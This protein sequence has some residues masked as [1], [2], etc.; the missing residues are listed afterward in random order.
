NHRQVS[1]ASAC[2]TAASSTGCSVPATV[3]AE[4]RNAKR[5]NNQHPVLGSAGNHVLSTA[6]SASSPGDVVVHT[7]TTATGAYGK[8]MNND[9]GPHDFRDVSAGGIIG[10]CGSTSA[11]GGGGSTSSSA[12]TPSTTDQHP[13]TTAAAAA[14]KRFV[15]SIDAAHASSFQQQ[16][17]R[18]V[19]SSSSSANYLRE[20]A[21]IGSG[22]HHLQRDFETKSRQKR[23]GGL[24][25]D[26]FRHPL[27]VDHHDAGPSH[28]VGKNYSRSS[29]RH[30][31]TSGLFR[32]DPHQ[33]LQQT[34]KTTSSTSWSRANNVAHVSF[35]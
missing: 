33:E 16:Q 28:S 3:A 21:S 15:N 20:L 12:T 19:G 5:T 4:V 6:G 13:A 11:N 18:G 9:V 30:H 29:S 14:A 2:S 8:K 35:L 10:S 24:G 17:G 25:G 34:Q 27:D 31:P 26:H 7:M 1:K 23:E 22:S 32:Q